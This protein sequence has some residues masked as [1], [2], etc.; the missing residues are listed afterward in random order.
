MAAQ[1]GLS[2][3]WSQ[4]PTTGFLLTRPINKIGRVSGNTPIFKPKVTHFLETGNT[5]KKTNIR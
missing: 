1:S 3:R 5:E 2:L 4:M